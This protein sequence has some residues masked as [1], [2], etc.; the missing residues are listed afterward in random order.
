MGEDIHQL[1]VVDSLLWE[2]GAEERKKDFAKIVNGRIKDFQHVP[3]KPSVWCGKYRLTKKKNYP[4]IANTRNTGMCY[5]K[6]GHVL[7]CDDCSVLM[8]KW[9]ELMHAAAEARQIFCGIQIKAWEMKVENGEVKHHARPGTDSRLYNYH[10]EGTN[11]IGGALLYSNNFGVPMDFILA[12]NGMDEIF[13]GQ[14][15]VEDC[16][17]GARLEAS[18]QN[19]FLNKECAIME[20]EEAHLDCYVSRVGA[21]NLNGRHA[22]ETPC[23]ASC[24]ERRTWTVGNLFNMKELREK[25]LKGEPFEVPT[26]PERD[27]RDNQPLNCM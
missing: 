4:A 14:Y 10:L 25:T 7:F 16:E 21:K 19:I 23:D 3:P 5:A 8:P 27:W 15:G 24:R 11:P 12:V 2:D 17:F 6:H 9:F 20:S 22:N 13:D 18:G 1:I 26:Q